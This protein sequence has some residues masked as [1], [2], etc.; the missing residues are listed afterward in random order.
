VCLE[1]HPAPENYPENCYLPLS[2]V[3]PGE[4]VKLVRVATG[5]R[6]RRRLTE[7]GLIPGVEFK[8]MQDEGGPLLLA[9]K[10]TRLALGRG[11]AH[12]IIVQTA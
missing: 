8:I 3:E 11:M 1:D 12:K 2:M 4:S 5:H 9:V 10:D 7:L 6:L